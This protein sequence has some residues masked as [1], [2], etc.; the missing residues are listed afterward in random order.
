[1]GLRRLGEEIELGNQTDMKPYNL[2]G[3]IGVH[4]IPLGGH[5]VQLIQGYR[6]L[7]VVVVVAVVVVVV[8]VFAT[9]AA[10]FTHAVAT[11][12]A[13]ML[14]VVVVVRDAGGTTAE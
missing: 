14:V 9:A 12:V 7:V 8:V 5:E 3:C 10:A 4:V 13:T 1:M 6:G 11:G 2:S